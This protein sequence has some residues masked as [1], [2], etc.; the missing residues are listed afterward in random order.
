MSENLPGSIMGD[1]T[2]KKQNPSIDAVR[3]ILFQNERDRIVE[4]EREVLELKQ[5][6]AE[7]QAAKLDELKLIPIIQANMVELAQIATEKQRPEMAEAIGP[8]MSDALRVQIRENYNDTAEVISQLIGEATRLQVSNSPNEIRDALAPIMFSSISQA[9]SDQIRELQQQIDARLSNPENPNLVQKMWMRLTGVDPTEVLFRR[10]LPFEVRE[11]FLIQNESGL[12]ICHYSTI[13]HTSDSDLI[14]AM[15]TAIRDFVGDAFQ[16]TSTEGLELREI[17]Y[18]DQQIIIKSGEAIYCAVVVHGILP[19]GFR[20]YLQKFVSQLHLTYRNQFLNYTGDPE[21]LPNFQPQL[22]GF[23]ERLSAEGGKL[24]GQQNHDSRPSLTKKQLLPY[25]IG[26]ALF[27][28]LT[29]CSL[30][31]FVYQLAPLAIYGIPTPEPIRVTVV[32]TS[33]PTRIRSSSTPLIPITVYPTIPVTIYKNRT[34]I[35]LRTRPN[36]ELSETISINTTMT[37]IRKEAGWILVSYQDK[38]TG[39]TKKGWVL[40]RLLTSDQP[41][42]AVTNEPNDR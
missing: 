8:V 36:G 40:E 27:F 24:G 13:D 34:P 23:V 35:L 15:L 26:C 31:W 2:P 4:L 39:E 11:I 12:L 41:A 14:G 5:I 32:V 9:V 7:L 10:S 16:G 28:L 42:I 18:G 29:L 19:E 21:T 3:S 6:L 38:L 30:S 37:A 1:T 22:N 25:G 17:Q 33:T 20:A